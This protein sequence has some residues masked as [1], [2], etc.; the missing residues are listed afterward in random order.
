MDFPCV[1]GARRGCNPRFRGAV[2]I[3]QKRRWRC[4]YVL[5]GPSAFFR[6]EKVTAAFK[7]FQLGSADGEFR[8]GPR[9]EGAELDAGRF[10]TAVEAGDSETCDLDFNPVA[11]GEHFA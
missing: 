11:D 2:D 3:R 6:T 10:T 8:R 5:R 1:L 4:D 7:P 9:G